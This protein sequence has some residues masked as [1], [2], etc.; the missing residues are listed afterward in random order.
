MKILR[1]IVLLS[2]SLC[3]SFASTA[4]HEKAKRP[5]LK[6]Y[7]GKS[8]NAIAPLNAITQAQ[9]RFLSYYSGPIDNDFGPN[10]RAALK[11][12]QAGVGLNPNGVINR[13][14][15]R[16]LE[17][18]VNRSISRRIDKNLDGRWAKLGDCKRR[19][20][21]VRGNIIIKRHRGRLSVPRLDFIEFTGKT[22]L[23]LMITRERT[24]FSVGK[25][26]LLETPPIKSWL[27]PD[28][29]EPMLEVIEA[30]SVLPKSKPSNLDVI[31]NAYERCH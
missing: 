3:L 21:E 22:R 13:A 25:Q 26:G 24:D 23:N 29:E 19:S 8:Q 18:R 7:L 9:L 10:S 14:T 16:V 11:R 1:L 28:E 15:V 12:F 4:D 2:L 20:I 6:A 31:A 17:G 5:L 30:G 27:F